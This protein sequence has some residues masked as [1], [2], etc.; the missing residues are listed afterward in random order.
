MK[1]KD[2]T[3]TEMEKMVWAAAFANECTSDR[4]FLEAN[5]RTIDDISGYSC[6]ERADVCLEKYREAIASDDAGFLI[7]VIEGHK[8]KGQDRD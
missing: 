8:T 4:A 1:T 3:M 5:G 6:A 7:P 2:R